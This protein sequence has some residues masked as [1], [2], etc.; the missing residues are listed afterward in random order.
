MPVEVSHLDLFVQLVHLA[1]LKWHA[2]VQHDVEDD[3]KGPDVDLGALVQ[4]L[5]EEFGSRKVD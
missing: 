2:T 1:V 5:D 4:C 3:A